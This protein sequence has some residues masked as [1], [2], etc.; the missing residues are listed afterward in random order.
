L[1]SKLATFSQ[2]KLIEQKFGAKDA[3]AWASFADNGYVYVPEA[4]KSG[5][6]C[7]LHVAFHGCKQGGDNDH[8]FGNIFARFAGYNEWA[9]NNRIVVLYPQVQAENYLPTVNPQGC[10]DWWGFLYTGPDYAT[11]SGKQIK[12][13]AQMINILVHDEHFLPIPED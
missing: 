8:P 12:A 4:C 7:R 9:K 10:W 3:G 6:Q 2:S 1:S 5:A 13:V 11:L